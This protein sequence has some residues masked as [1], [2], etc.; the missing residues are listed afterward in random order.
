MAGMTIYSDI[1]GAP[2]VEAV[3]AD[4][5][6]RLLADPSLVHYFDGI[7]LDRLKRHQRAFV[8][9]AL[10]GPDGY[11]GRNMAPAH[12]GLNITNAAFSTVVRH[13][14]DTLSDAGVSDDTIIAIGR[15][16]IPYQRDVVTAENEPAAFHAYA[17]Q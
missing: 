2:A 4:F 3:V 7:D 12:A 17:G 14:C 5:Y 13:L 16:L 9:A 8:S 1:G 15:A 10:G 11:Q 6:E